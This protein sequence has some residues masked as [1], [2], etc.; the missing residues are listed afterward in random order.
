MI[1]E[2]NMEILKKNLENVF[3][4]Y[5]KKFKNEYTIECFKRGKNKDNIFILEFGFLVYYLM[6]IFQ[7]KATNEN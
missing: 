2:F 4:E 3:V 1:R 6:R 5:E 7:D